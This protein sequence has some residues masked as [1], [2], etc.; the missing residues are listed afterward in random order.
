MTG[1]S[2]GNAVVPYVVIYPVTQQHNWGPGRLIVEV[3]RSQTGTRTHRHTQTHTDTHTHTHTET[4][5]HAHTDTQTRAHTHRHTHT[6]THRHTQAHTHRHAH[7]HAH[8]RART[9]T[10]VGLLSTSDQPVAEGAI[11]TTHNKH[12]IRNSMASAGFEPANPASERPH[13][14]TLDRAARI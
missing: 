10:Q 8:A 2:L 11:Y 14:C 12:K 13:T 7:A 5:V 6:H 4:R 1:L 3:S 9:H